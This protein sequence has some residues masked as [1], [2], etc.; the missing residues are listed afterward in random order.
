VR[1]PKPTIPI[2]V[3]RLTLFGFALHITDKRTLWLGIREMTAMEALPCRILQH[4]AQHGPA[5]NAELAEALGSYAMAISRAI[6]QAGLHD[7]PKQIHVSAWVKTAG[8][9]VALWAYGDGADAKRIK[10]RPEADEED[11]ERRHEIRKKKR[12]AHILRMIRLRVES[13][14]KASPWQI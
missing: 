12:L 5:T 10:W 9:P 13:G 1:K 8:R 14:Q 4:L 11:E 2:T 7:A 3:G 6:R